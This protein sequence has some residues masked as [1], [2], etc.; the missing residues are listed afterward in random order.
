VQQHVDAG[1]TGIVPTA[2][3]PEPETPESAWDL[4]EALA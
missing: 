3:P 2:L 1:A 4:V